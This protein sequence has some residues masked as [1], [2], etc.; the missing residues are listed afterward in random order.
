[1]EN[2]VR[3][4]ICPLSTTGKSISENGEMDTELSMLVKICFYLSISS[5]EFRLYYCAAMKPSNCLNWLK[6][7]AGGLVSKS[8][9]TLEWTTIWKRTHTIYKEHQIIDEIIRENYMEQFIELK[10]SVFCLAS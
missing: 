1:M 8:S 5:I 2:F 7:R 9:S 10:T 6:K 3:F 4:R